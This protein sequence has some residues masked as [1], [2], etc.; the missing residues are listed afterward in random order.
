MINSDNLFLKYLDPTFFNL[1]LWNP[2]YIHARQFP[3]QDDAA[4]GM[5][6]ERLIGL[7]PAT[8]VIQLRYSA[9]VLSYFWYNSKWLHVHIFLHWYWLCNLD[10]FAVLPACSYDGED[11]V[12]SDPP[13]VFFPTSTLETSFVLFLRAFRL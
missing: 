5:E 7:C 2:V 13:N 12:S 3:I 4:A 8:L 1:K 9:I 6:E 10:F 11:S